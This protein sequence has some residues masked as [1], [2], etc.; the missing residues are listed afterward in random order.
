LAEIKHFFTGAANIVACS[1]FNS[2]GKI[3]SQT[4]ESVLTPGQIS[5]KLM[6]AVGNK[7]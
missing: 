4:A 6:N 3:K 7:A 2:I 5:F 1:D